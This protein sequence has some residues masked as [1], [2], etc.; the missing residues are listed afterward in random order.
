M[1]HP[2][3]LVFAHYTLVWCPQIIQR[4]TLPPWH[5]LDYFGP[6]R[7]LCTAR[8]G[9]LRGLLLM[10]RPD[11]LTALM[12]IWASPGFPAAAVAR[13]RWA[14]LRVSHICFVSQT[15]PFSTLLA[16]PVFP[17]F[18]S[19]ELAG[20]SSPST[21]PPKDPKADCVCAVPVRLQPTSEVGT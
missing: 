21:S 2:S 19:W 11:S 7:L 10:A 8:P 6:C 18:I 1:F 3:P 9:P 14:P 16:R 15:D 12:P 20:R 17:G 13:L 5:Y 4:L